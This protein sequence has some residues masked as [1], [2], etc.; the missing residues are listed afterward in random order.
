MQTQHTLML[1]KP[2]NPSVP[3]SRFLVRLAPKPER[4][5]HTRP[6]LGPRVQP[7]MY[8]YEHIRAVR[9]IDSRR[10]TQS[11]CT[12]G[13]LLFRDAKAP[14]NSAPFVSAVSSVKVIAGVRFRSI[15]IMTNE[16]SPIERRAV[17]PD[18]R[19]IIAQSGRTQLI[20]TS[21]G[22]IELL[23][24]ENFPSSWGMLSLALER[25]LDSS[26]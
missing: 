20:V 2:S 19:T 18:G 10:I 22:R 26:E 13:K 6:T 24:R 12:R 21:E 23:T 3:E 17:L 1:F 4:S 25:L 7:D 16:F 8:G 9:R 5:A 11:S 14:A 15:N